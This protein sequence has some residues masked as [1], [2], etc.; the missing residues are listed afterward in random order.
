MSR[1]P[2]AI[3]SCLLG[4]VAAL[5]AL[6]AI[7]QQSELDDKPPLPRSEPTHVLPAKYR[8][9]TSRAQFQAIEDEQPLRSERENADE[10]R[11][12]NEVVV[13]ARQFPAADLEKVAARFLTG[14]DLI[15]DSRRN[16]KLKPVYFEG[17][18]TNVQRVEPRPSLKELGVADTYQ[19]VLTPTDEPLAHQLCIVF[20]E[21]PPGVES[22]EK[23][24]GK[25]VS[26]AGYSFKLLLDPPADSRGV[27]ASEWKRIPLLIGRSVTPLPGPPAPEGDSVAS[28]PNKHLRIFQKIHD[29]AAMPGADDSRWEEGAAWSWVALYARKFPTDL[30]E[31]KARKLTFADLF[32][33]NRSDYKLDLVYFR[34]RL[35]RL[36]E[37]KAPKRLRDAGV[38][39]FY[40]GWLV[41]LDEPRGNPVCIILTEL[42]PGLEPAMSMNRE[43]TFAGYSFKLLR[44]KSEERDAKGA[45][46]WKRA[47]LLIGRSVT[48]LPEPEPYNGGTWGSFFVPASLIGLAV[49]LG[50]AGLLSWWFR[51]GDAKVKQALADRRVNPFGN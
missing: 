42:P 34:G 41:P 12:W 11:S 44:Y 37:D 51:R 46:V 4:C 40:E 20:S 3:S 23:L 2:A 45:N 16:F 25:W 39:N 49:I 26:F 35:I 38:E 13:F 31:K 48:L 18:L 8:I 6:P 27:P 21:L 17:Q 32:E 36:R 43:V 30:L 22:A 33:K 47:P 1:R 15:N 10:F 5:F 19:A 50:T 24:N 28:I 29:D 14:E 7:A 9:D